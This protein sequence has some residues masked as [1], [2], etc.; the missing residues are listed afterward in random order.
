MRFEDLAAPTITSEAE[1]GRF[2]T[3]PADRR[4]VSFV[5][6]GDT[7][8]QG[9]GIDEARG[10]MRTYATMRNNRPDFFIHSGDSIYA[11]CPIQS[12][13]KLSN[14]E[15]WR[16]IVTE[17]KSRVAQT[18]ADYRGNYKYNLLDANLRA[19]QRR[20]AGVRA[21]GRPRSRQ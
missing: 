3:A 19:L 20:G 18:L 4:A 16:N 21:M 5:W 9:W 17:E 13:L 6:S 11:D 8:G 12:T 7:A 15:I 2:R 10:G 14:G 1:V